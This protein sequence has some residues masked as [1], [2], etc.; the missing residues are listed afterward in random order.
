M[1]TWPR[2]LIFGS[3]RPYW[4]ALPAA[5]ALGLLSCPARANK[6]EPAPP[7]PTPAPTLSVVGRTIAQDQGGWVVDYRLRYRGEKAIVVAPTDMTVKIDGWVS[8][9]RVAAHAT[10]RMSSLVV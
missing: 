10:P 7:P 9:S 5:L 8:N 1:S 4:I 3:K 6:P 2:S